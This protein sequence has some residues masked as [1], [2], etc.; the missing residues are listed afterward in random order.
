MVLKYFISGAE[1]FPCW[2][3]ARSE[4]PDLFASKLNVL[5]QLFQLVVAAAIATPETEKIASNGREALLNHG[6]KA[7]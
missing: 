5:W 6:Q 4:H 1:S 3:K 2:F 7:A